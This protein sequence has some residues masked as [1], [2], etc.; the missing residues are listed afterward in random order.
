[1]RFIYFL[2][3][4]IL[5]ITPAYANTD[6]LSS[7]PEEL[8][9]WSDWVMF[10]NPD[11]ACP[12]EA[13]NTNRSCSF[14]SLLN[15]DIKPDNATFKMKVNNRKDDWV[16]LPGSQTYWPRD[17]QE[18]EK[19][20]P[21][22][23]Y[24]GTPS[25][26]LKKGSHTLS[27]EISWKYRPNS[28]PVPRNVALFNLTI[29]GK[30][31]KH[32]QRNG[33]D[34]IATK[35]TES[36]PLYM[37][38]DS[39][40]TEVYRQIQD[41]IPA[42]VTTQIKLTVTGKKRDE[43]LPSPLLAG[44]ALSSLSAGGLQAHLNEDKGKLYVAVRAGTY[45]IT[46]Q[47]RLTSKLSELSM[48][49]FPWKE[50]LWAFAQDNNLRH[51]KVEGG[52]GINP[53]NTDMPHYWK[54][55]ATYLMKPGNKLTFVEQR[56]GEEQVKEN[57]LSLNRTAWL[58]M[59]GDEV[60]VSDSITG[61]LSEGWDLSFNGGSLERAEANGQ[62]LPI[63]ENTKTGT[64][65][66]VRNSN[67]SLN[68][69][70]QNTEGTNFLGILKLP[71]NGWSTDITNGSLSIK[72]SP[73]WKV[74]GIWSS[75]N[76]T[77]TW[78][79]KWDLYDV[80]S[81][82][83]VALAV[84]K[85]WGFKWGTFSF[86]SVG[87]AFQEDPD[88]AAI[89]L[90]IVATVAL[91]KIVPQGKLFKFINLVRLFTLLSFVIFLL[92]Y[93]VEHIRYAMYPQ[94]EESHGYYPSRFAANVYGGR[95]D[96]D[97]GFAA[98]EM[99]MDEMD[100]FGADKEQRLRKTVNK[101]VAS[102]M[103]APSTVA[104]MAG[105]MYN[106]SIMEL[107][108]EKLDIS[109][110]PNASLPTGIGLPAW[111]WRSASVQWHAPIA[112]EE[113]VTVWLLTP[114]MYRLLELLKAALLGIL[115]IRLMMQKLPEQWNFIGIKRAIAVL[116]V[117]LVTTV[118]SPAQADIPS[119]QL[120][121]QLKSRLMRQAECIPNCADYATADISVSGD[122]ISLSLD[123]LVAEDSIVPLPQ[124]GY[125]W[126]PSKVILNGKEEGILIRDGNE[127]KVLL[128]AG[129]HKVSMSGYMP[130]A[131][132]ANLYFPLKPR[133]VDVKTAGW[134]FSG[135]DVNDQVSNSLNFVRVKKAV[136][137][138]NEKQSIATHPTYIPPYALV[139]RTL[140]M[141]HRW[142]MTTQINLMYGNG[143]EVEYPLMEDEKL[144]DTH[145]KIKDGKVIV[146]LS[147]QSR[148]VQFRSIITP[149]DRLE[150]TAP[151]ANPWH[152]VWVVRP[153][154]LWNV[155]PEGISPVH[156]ISSNTLEFKWRPFAGEKVTLLNEKPKS[157][158]G[159]T[160]TL[161]NATLNI[162]PGEKLT[163][164]KLSIGIETTKPQD[165]TFTIPE[166]AKL[167][168]LHLN[169]RDIPLS[170]IERDV[171]VA[172]PYGKQNIQAVWHEADADGIF[173][174]TPD[175][176]LN[177]PATNLTVRVH[178]PPHRFVLYACGKWGPAVLLWSIL[179]AYA[180][181]AYALSK[182]S[183][184]PLKG[185]QWFL[186]ALGFSQVHPLALIIPFGCLIVLGLKQ[187]HAAKLGRYG[188]NAL[189]IVLVILVVSALGGTLEAIRI[190][191]QGG[192]ETY[193]TG[194]GS[195]ANVLQWYMDRTSG[196][197]PSIFTMM[198]PSWIYQWVLM[199]LWAGWTAY[200]FIDKLALWVWDCFSAHGYWH[201]K[202]EA[203]KAVKAPA[204]KIAKKAKK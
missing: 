14:P 193:I 8:K 54:Q 36:K 21:V 13:R 90:V 33:E 188:F 158:T 136:V 120:L 169:G 142:I 105:N 67:L 125:P 55:Y 68:A 114:F 148:Y 59:S 139:T 184:V 117:A 57:R 133:K 69:V 41:G 81:L 202:E 156:R 135:L 104:S 42:I 52:N 60:T 131:Q 28:I 199:L 2:L 175:V 106:D 96:M 143:Q 80:F 56:R 70:S 151:T 177:V 176:N 61:T 204:K 149:M 24:R 180:I 64:T 141:G 165:Y 111:Q 160:L 91:L 192:A 181:L 26:Y 194:G 47:E 44:S 93:M 77:G 109:F 138:T 27:G 23:L 107:K 110:D 115:A 102:I 76:E 25:V 51:I 140:E 201:K 124:L 62:I 83:L 178:T 162:H 137:K 92:P 94:L 122:K 50:E 19:A 103:N 196:E 173:M 12:H 150:M 66:S 185:W 146:P 126:Q 22:V 164:S 65:I 45:W 75:G 1:M 197:L 172:L 203:K 3:V 182:V 166:G 30:E 168:T 31:I 11:Y 82:L 174:T 86:I 128:D 119:P 190:G 88:I 74:M 163:E 48:P 179:F 39:I 134:S 63:S 4:S 129:K 89:I 154:S 98:Q 189:Q 170:Q 112:Q 40:E 187:Q 58:G 113:E 35:H 85:L 18:G 130:E 101:G 132:Q 118:A 157:V 159:R 145:F 29:D 46:I 108:K 161:H 200:L 17:V 78:F 84:G 7:T 73:G 9:K 15:L 5:T 127:L 37:E 100:Y 116:L 186:L 32:P 195:S 171:V 99:A 34:F 10:D 16:S 167:Q 183:I 87:L 121:D 153:S 95:T 152:E 72:T 79:S 43:V 155:T 71:A 38:E 147:P 20:I 144:L 123:I 49:T 191:L 6:V 198:P 53:S 97:I